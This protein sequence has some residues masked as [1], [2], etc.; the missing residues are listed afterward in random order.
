MGNIKQIN[1]KGF[2]ALEVVLVIVVVAILAATGYYAYNS[3]KKAS[4]TLDSV[5]SVNSATQPKF[6]KNTKQVT[7]DKTAESQAK[8]IQLALS[9]YF[10]ANNSYPSDL[11]PANLLNL[12][13]SGLTSST[14]TAP[15]GTKFSY[16]ATPSGCTTSDKKCNYYVLEV[17]DV[18]TNQVVL[19]LH[20]NTK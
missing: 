5:S 3:N 11:S 14:F 13:I 19:V 12:N 4:S 17:I 20:S 2:A 1:Q 16:R 10:S 15:S 9:A 7:S 6:T 18:N 8:T